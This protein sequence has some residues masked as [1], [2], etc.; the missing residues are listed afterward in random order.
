MAELL[1]RPQR[2]AHQRRADAAV[3]A[4]ARDRDRPEQQR[5]PLRPGGDV[6][7]PHGADDAPVLGRDERQSVGRQPAVAQALRGLGEA[8][9]AE[10]LIE[11]RFARDNVAGGLLTDRDHGHALPRLVRGV[12]SPIGLTGGEP[13]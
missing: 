8:A 3:L 4:V 13:A 7:Q 6:P 5:R 2:M 9:F 10:G 12:V 11:Q 1:G